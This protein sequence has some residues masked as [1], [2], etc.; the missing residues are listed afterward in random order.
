MSD[1]ETEQSQKFI[2]YL[3]QH[4]SSD[5]TVQYT[6]AGK[7]VCET[8]WRLVCG[9]RFNRFS[10]L[11]QKLQNGVVD[12]Q[13][14]RQGIVQPQEHTLRMTSWLKMFTEKVGDRMPMNKDL[15]LPSCLTK[16]DI[17]INL[18]CEDLMQGSTGRVQCISLSTYYN[19]W[20]EKFSHVKIPKVCILI[21]CYICT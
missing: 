5:N 18:A 7:L 19:L 17:Y 4:S 21:V 16:F 13:H 3:I 9:L 6:I 1:T 14:G 15:H 11:K 10:T 12:V 8:C 2:D 20:D